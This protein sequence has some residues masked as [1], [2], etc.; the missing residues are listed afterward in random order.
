M[1]GEGAEPELLAAEENREHERDDESNRRK[2]DPAARIGRDEP[3]PFFVVHSFYRRGILGLEVEGFQG[4]PD[5][6]APSACATGGMRPNAR[7]E[8]EPEATRRTGRG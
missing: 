8:P 1:I 6:R 2:D 7:P 3:T 4:L 5:R